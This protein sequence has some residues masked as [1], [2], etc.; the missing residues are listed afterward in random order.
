[1]IRL[2]VIGL[3]VGL[4]LLR[5]GS[6]LNFAYLDLRLV[7]LALIGFAIQLLIFTPLGAPLEQIGIIP[8]FYL[9]SMALLIAWA[10][11][12]W[13]VVGMP[14]MGLGLLCNTLAIAANGGY[15][16]VSPE[17]ARYAGRLSRYDGLQPPILNNSILLP[18]DQIHLWILT[19][20]LALPAGTPF[21]NVFSIG[22]VLLTI[23]IAVLCYH[24]ALHHNKP[25]QT[26]TPAESS[27][28]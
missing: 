17:P 25:A 21:A 27:S 18:P 9:L 14:F 23:G 5:G 6:L 24:T 7:P 15:M 16:P 12:N 8:A 26:G 28:R 1:M 2:V 11:L 13:R 4:A 10:A 20:I 19:D 22:D 3:A